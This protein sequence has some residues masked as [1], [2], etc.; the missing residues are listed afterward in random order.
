[1]TDNEELPVAVAA[2]WGL[3]EGARPRARGLSL[4]RIVDAGIRVA[5]AE[6]LAAV[7]MNRVAAELGA[8]PMSLYRHLTAKDELLAHMVDT[9]YASAP[10]P[11]EAG[12]SWRDGLNRWASG[13]LVVLRRHPWILRIPIGGPPIMPNHVLWFERGLACLRDTRLLP[14]EKPSVLLLVNGFVRNQATLEAD[15]TIA[16]RAA[17]VAPEEAGAAYS[18]R[19]ARLTGAERFP[20]IRALLEAHVFD[21]SATI[22]DDFRFGLDRILDGVEALVRA[23]AAASPADPPA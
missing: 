5:I 4:G 15:L 14:A 2:A 16:A 17:G 3:R 10:A 8:A 1:M 23:R 21:G 6:G 22:V 20:A 18:R 11:P 9:A 13:H 7:S 19:L 12:E